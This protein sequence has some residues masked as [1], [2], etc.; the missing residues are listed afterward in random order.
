MGF[1]FLGGP[2]FLHLTA[3][4]RPLGGGEKGIGKKTW[5]EKRGRMPRGRHMQMGVPL[6]LREGIVE[7]KVEILAEKKEGEGGKMVFCLKEGMGGKGEKG[8]DKR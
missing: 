4:F 7:R 1:C 8:G 3:A 2:F 6:Y 5:G